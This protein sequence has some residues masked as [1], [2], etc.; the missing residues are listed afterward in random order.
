MNFANQKLSTEPRSLSEE[1]PHIKIGYK[2][3]I[4]LNLEA[5]YVASN[6]CT[7]KKL[8]FQKNSLSKYVN[9]PKVQSDSKEALKKV[10]LKDLMSSPPAVFDA[11]VDTSLRQP[12][13]IEGG[14][15]T[16]VKKCGSS[17]VSGV[18]ITAKMPSS[19]TNKD[20]ASMFASG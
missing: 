5:G 11:D 17:F 1:K 18:K 15:K 7:Q 9:C 14:A 19:T 4:K 3:P 2:T 13:I 16:S 6:P 20:H 12:M 10:A 8:S